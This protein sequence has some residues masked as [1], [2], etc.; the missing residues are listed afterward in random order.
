[1]PS[2]NWFYVAEELTD[3]YSA[4]LQVCDV[5][6]IRIQPAK[7]KF[8]CDICG[9]LYAR[10]K[11]LEKHRRKH[12]SGRNIASSNQSVVQQSQMN[13][14]AGENPPQSAAEPT[15]RVTVM[16][17]CDGTRDTGNKRYVCGECG[18]SFDEESDVKSHMFTK[19]MCK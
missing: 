11:M 17:A 19:H 3:I 12:E 16:D 15:D 18:D 13:G 5:P 1:V 4:K 9:R 8:A 7:Q 14:S 10:P 6:G 2:V